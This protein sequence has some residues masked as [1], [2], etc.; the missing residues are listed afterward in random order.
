MKL[1]LATVTNIVHRISYKPGYRLYVD[2][3][4]SNHSV[5]VAIKA[6]VKNSRDPHPTGTDEVE[7]QATIEVPLF[8]HIFDSEEDLVLYLRDELITLMELHER[9]EWFKFDGILVKDP[10][11]YDRTARSI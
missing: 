8:Q 5:R 11:Q 9:D 2:F 6:M 4:P 10:H 3:C 1:D 7:F